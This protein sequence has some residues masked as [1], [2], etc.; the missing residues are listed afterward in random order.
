MQFR[1]FENSDLTQY[2]RWVNRREI[3]EVDNSGP[4]QVRTPESFAE[5]WAK[6]VGWQRSWIINSELQWSGFFVKRRSWG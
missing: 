1:L 3:W 2:L 5:Q 4:F 6:I